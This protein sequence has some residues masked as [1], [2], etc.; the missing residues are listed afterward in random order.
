MSTKEAESR[1]A[2][3]ATT[4]AS[5]RNGS[6]AST[7]VP[8]SSDTGPAG[9]ERSQ[10]Q[11]SSSSYSEPLRYGANMPAS[12]E[13]LFDGAYDSDHEMDGAKDAVPPD[14]CP[15][16][17]I[18]EWGPQQSC[19]RSPL[20]IDDAVLSSVS[21][22]SG[23]VAGE[24]SSRVNFLRHVWQCD[25]KLPLSPSVAGRM[26]VGL[27]ASA[28]CR[29]YV[30]RDTGDEETNRL[31][32]ATF[33]VDPAFM[34]AH[35]SGQRYRPRDRPWRGGKGHSA[36]FSACSYVYPQTLTLTVN[37]PLPTGSPRG[38]GS[39]SQL[40]GPGA[41]P[42]TPAS[43]APLDNG[44]QHQEK[45]EATAPVAESKAPS[46][47][48]RHSSP[49]YDPKTEMISNPV[50][51]FCRASLWASPRAN[52]LFLDR[53][54][55]STSLEDALLEALDDTMGPD[56]APDQSD[57]GTQ[58]ATAARTLEDSLSGLVY[59][60]WLDF[61]D[62]LS[63]S[64]REINPGRINR[65]L[66]WGMSQYLEQNLTIART[67]EKKV[68]MA[69]Q[70]QLQSAQET[71][72]A[73]LEN[74]GPF[75]Y[76]GQQFAGSDD[77]K[78]LLSRLERIVA[79]L[80]LQS[81]NPLVAATGGNMARFTAS[82]TSYTVNRIPSQDTQEVAIHSAPELGLG[83][84]TSTP[85]G[86]LPGGIN[87]P[88][89]QPFSRTP[90]GQEAL[91]RISYMG[92]ILLPFS[93]IAGVLSM[94][95]PFGPGDRL[96]WVFWVITLPITCFT[97]TIIYADDIR[98]AY[99]WK[100]MSHKSLQ[101]AINKGEAVTADA[102]ARL[103]HAA[104][105][106]IDKFSSDGDPEI[107]TDPVASAVRLVDARG[108]NGRRARVRVT[109]KSGPGGPTFYRLADVSNPESPPVSPVSAQ[110]PPLPEPATVRI[111]TANVELSGA[112]QHARVRRR[113]GILGPLQQLWPR[114][115]QPNVPAS[116]SLH[117]ASSARFADDVEPGLP[118]GDTVVIDV[119]RPNVDSGTAEMFSRP[120]SGLNVAAPGCP[121]ILLEQRNDELQPKAW[122]L[123]QLGW[124]G[125]FKTM[126]GY[127]RP[128]D[129]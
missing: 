53:N 89:R 63:V 120:V 122:R 40:D 46:Q 13:P 128:R 92:G 96:F 86:P 9:R 24:S 19:V 97:L 56:S 110:G 61:V 10:Q 123:Q 84:S 93:I 117:N 64:N 3:Q 99:I 44:L 2:T 51:M 49:T 28:T 105:R 85:K 73:S 88:S 82:D 1:A 129:A 7:A 116:T 41:K 102:A 59:D 8:P 65:K 69:K 95:D 55:S 45:N 66:L 38:S 81:R 108:S 74:A 115:S 107:E 32:C 119:V 83:S 125:A 52:V 71:D 15:A 16:A 27:P 36:T 94:S 34:S 106:V 114:K 58:L 39:N 62:T 18:L 87:D 21:S 12:Y 14:T 11:T 124:V 80:P 54:P 75:Y 91:S 25:H 23:G 35:I 43:Q 79:L 98:K 68:H 47:E 100:P 42:Q 33:D 29:L 57:N 22:L 37:K 78:E 121:T 126:V 70:H 90:E 76:D 48:P 60:Q 118:S 67:H 50:V 20:D 72:K 101:D 6:S 103:A 5:M 127:Q 109:T 104:E 26:F 4:P 77:W 17:Y 31:L 113:L 112:I 30:L 111:A